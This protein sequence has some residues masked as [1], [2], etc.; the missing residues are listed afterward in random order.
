M[1]CRQRG[2]NPP[3]CLRACVCVCVCVRAWHR[4][5]GVERVCVGWQSM[6]K[7]MIPVHS[8]QCWSKKKRSSCWNKSIQVLTKSPVLIVLCR[9]MYTRYKSWTHKVLSLLHLT[10]LSKCWG[11][12]WSNVMT[13]FCTCCY[14]SIKS[15]LGAAVDRCVKFCSKPK[16]NGP[17]P[18]N[19][20]H[21][22]LPL[23]PLVVFTFCH[24]CTSCVWGVGHL[25]ERHA[26]ELTHEMSPSSSYFK[27]GYKEF[28]SLTAMSLCL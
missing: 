13:N 1:L 9:V 11:S 28:A 12:T 2:V 19:G 3:T 20:V 14:L 10:I 26:A 15:P 21:Q 22:A 5:E 24:C 25:L 7:T 17:E 18:S 6:R 23:T 16:W 27:G 4:S 8:V